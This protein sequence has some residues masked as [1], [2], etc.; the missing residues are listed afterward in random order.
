MK[1][2]ACCILLLFIFF[3][4]FSNLYSQ[5]KYGN[6]TKEELE[7]T[8][9]SADTTAAAVMLLKTG[10]TR[11]VYDERSGF[12]FEFTMQV[13]IKILKT[14]GL[15]WC[16]N[17]ISYYEASSRNKEEIRGLSGTTYNL[18][19]G[20][21]VK[22]KLSK[23]NIFDEDTDNKWKVKK[24]TMPAAKVGSVIEY[25]Y[26][27]VSDFFYDLRSFYFQSSIPI[28]NTS[29]EVTIPEY[30][31]YNVDFQGYI[32][33]D[34]KTEPVNETIFM[35]LTDE[36]GRTQ[37]VNHK[38]TA[39]RYKFTGNNIP[40]LKDESYLWTVGDFISRVGF[41]L[42]TIQMPYQTIKSFSTT[43]ANID[44]ELFDSSSFGGNLK[45]SDLFKE[46]ISKTDVNLERAK[47][48]QDMVKYKVKWND[49]TSFYPTNLKDVLKNSIGNSADVNFLLINALKSGGFDAFPVLLST[50]SNG[51]IPFTYPSISAFN[52]VITGIRIDTT[53]YFTDAA[54]K[55]GDW[56]LLPPKCLVP[57]ARILENDYRD[58]VD[59]TGFS[60]GSELQ[61]AHCSFVDSQRKAK[62]QVT[63]K[64]IAAYNARGVY[65]GAK[66]KDA[67]V[68]QTSKD[69]SATIDDFNISNLDN[70]GQ[71]LKM[72]YVQGAD[73]ALG[74][75][76]LYVNPLI[77]NFY[78][79]NPF[80]EEKREF[81]VQFPYL[82][83]YAQ[84]V[85]L[86]IPDGYV[87][88]E[89]PKSEKL[90]MNDDD[91]SLLYRIV[92]TDKA[93]RLQYQYKLKKIQFLPN[94]YDL[95]KD[96]FAKLVLKNSEQIV[97]K[98]KAAEEQ[99]VNNVVN[100]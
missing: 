7:M 45:K 81:P 2:N 41:E 49:R 85:T 70:T 40:A 16:D 12:R 1:K 87:I 51:R 14:E 61:I 17:D 31:R 83:N 55:Y 27:I 26:T 98:K 95:L 33:I 53:L 42:K 78:K 46:E 69:L 23:D 48:I 25:K 37:S 80:K 99:P 88:D 10:E 92:A 38:C 43:W 75:E 20:K 64:G 3:C 67:F 39:E 90:V 15:S 84:V 22:T 71:E 58:W 34:T 44:K 9:Y 77:D 5:S 4:S 65:F 52:Y 97:F 13:K 19:D 62:T 32:R 89:L 91:I 100:E 60:E 94:E 93:I 54:T 28:V 96:F 86:D 11:F 68:E 72:E 29:Y 6:A 74:D 8:E 18:E 47:E 30:F 76:F 82:Y 66:D 79:T 56:N 24:I 63:L 35:R 50:R 59:L 21:I 57:Q 36:S 73:L